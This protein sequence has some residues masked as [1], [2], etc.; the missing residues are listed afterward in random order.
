VLQWRG[1][2]IFQLDLESG[3]RQIALLFQLF[4]ASLCPLIVGSCVSAEQLIKRSFSPHRATSNCVI[5]LDDEL[6]VIV[7]ILPAKEADE[8]F[9]VTQSLSG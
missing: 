6:A 7:I 5:W 1:E 4:I 2:I 9:V 3:F 8:S